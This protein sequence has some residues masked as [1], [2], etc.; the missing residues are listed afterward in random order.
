MHVCT[1]IIQTND[2][3]NHSLATQLVVY[4]RTGREMNS[5]HAFFPSCFWEAHKLPI[6]CL[7]CRFEEQSVNF[8]EDKS[9]SQNMQQVTPPSQ[10]MQAVL[11]EWLLTCM[12][13]AGAYIM[14]P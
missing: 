9:L 14:E 3:V 2:M 13:G 12:V 1:Y 11:L 4:M 5:T 10:N 8:L 6:F 7:P